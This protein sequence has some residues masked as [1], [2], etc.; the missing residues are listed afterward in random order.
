MVLKRTRAPFAVEL[1][2]SPNFWGLRSYHS[3]VGHIS[4]PSLPAL[5]QVVR[6]Y[7]SPPATD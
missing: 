6:H 3:P 7:S 4:V 2:S 5:E 1:F